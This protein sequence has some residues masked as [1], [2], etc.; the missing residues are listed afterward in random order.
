MY[1]GSN[2]KIKVLTPDRFSWNR[3]HIVPYYVWYVYNTEYKYVT[4]THDNGSVLATNLSSKPSFPYTI[5]S[6]N[7]NNW[8]W[9]FSATLG[10]TPTLTRTNAHLFGNDGGFEVDMSEW[11]Q[12]SSLRISAVSYNGSSYIY[13]ITGI[14][15]V[16]SG[17][18]YILFG[19]DYL[20][21][22]DGKTYAK[23]YVAST[24][25]ISSSTGAIITTP[26]V[27]NSYY[28]IQ[29]DYNYSNKTQSTTNEYMRQP[30]MH[31]DTV[32]D[33]TSNKHPNNSY[34]PNSNLWYIKQSNTIDGK[35]DFIDVVYDEDSSAYPISG[36]QD[37]FWYEIM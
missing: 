17:R 26:H 9:A 1:Y 2:D 30:T 27:N 37:G 13:R 28:T 31:I 7:A 34:D 23:M 22:K 4:E 35:G 10:K 8:Y 36:A 3:Y 29:F 16:A 20:V 6:N 24:H 18:F 5:S 15:S 32:S 25:D 21:E 14:G 33:P 19:D 11:T 12:Y